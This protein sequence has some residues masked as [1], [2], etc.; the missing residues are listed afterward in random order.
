MAVIRKPAGLDVAAWRALLAE[1]SMRTEDLG[2]PAG[3]WLVAHE[4]GALVGGAG[5]EFAPDAALLRSLVVAPALR[6]RGLGLALADAC[7]DE[8]RRRGAAWLYTFS[9]DA[10]AFFQAAG[11]RETTPDEIAAALP[12]A[13]QVKLYQ[14]LKWLP[15]ERAFRRDLGAGEYGA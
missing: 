12:E 14:R 4:S 1:A 3:F 8:A 6:R 7:A 10:P 2:A 11:F 9:T 15:T 13:P 5:L